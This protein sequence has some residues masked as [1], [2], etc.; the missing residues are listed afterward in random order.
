V[1]SA[2]AGMRAERN[3]QRGVTGVTERAFQIGDTPFVNMVRGARKNASLEPGD[4]RRQ[5]KG[6]AAAC[7]VH[8]GIT[9]SRMLPTS[10]VGYWFPLADLW[11]REHLRGDAFLRG[12]IFV[13]GMLSE[14]P[15]SE[16]RNQ[17]LAVILSER[18][19]ERLSVRGW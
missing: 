17:K 2:M 6:E 19:P 14:C 4:T 10:S 7:F 1:R 3:P 11:K 13:C 8:T 5:W 15:E 9:S 16:I 12:C 18:G